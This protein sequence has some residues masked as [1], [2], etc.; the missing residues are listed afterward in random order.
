MGPPG[1]A[2]G[3]QKVTKANKR[4]FWLLCATLA[5][6][7]VDSSSVT[8]SNWRSRKDPYASL[9]EV[10]GLLCL[11][12]GPSFLDRSLEGASVEK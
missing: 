9:L 6:P 3:H 12:S 8:Q 7:V 10:E 11:V 2:S 5:L 4:L 1:S